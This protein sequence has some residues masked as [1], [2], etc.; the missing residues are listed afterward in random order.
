MFSVKIDVAFNKLPALTPAIIREARQVIQET[1]NE[2]VTVAQGFAPVDT[3]ELRDEI[4]AE[5]EG[6]LA[7]SV[8]SSTDHS[9]F[10]ELG[11]RYQPGTAFMTPMSETMRPQFID[12]MNGV[13]K[14]AAG[15]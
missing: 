4:H 5:D 15:G 6:D 1:V 3:G 10:Q 8:V 12:R 14:R 13:V 11:T 7:A 2:G 9:I